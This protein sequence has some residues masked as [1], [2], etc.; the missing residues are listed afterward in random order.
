MDFSEN[1]VAIVGT[2][3]VPNY[4]DLLFPL[5]ASFK[6]GLTDK[7][8]L[9]ISPTQRK[10]YF[11]D[12]RP[13]MTV[14]DLLRYNMV[15]RALLIGGGNIVHSGSAN[16][17]GYYPAELDR[18]AYPSL[19]IGAAA[20]ASIHNIPL[21]WNAPGVP[22][23]LSQMAA[24]VM[25]HI[26]R[27][28]SYI[29]VRD[30]SS[31]DNLDEP[32]DVRTSIIPD[33]VFSL[34]ELWAR[35]YLLQRFRALLQAH[36]R[37]DQ[38]PYLAIHVKARS[39]DA[40]IETMAAQIDSLS[41]K[42]GMTPILIALGHCHDDHV[43]ADRISGLLASEHINFARLTTLVDVAATLVGS[44]GY[45]GAS[46][47][48]YI[49]AVSYGVPA[50]IIGKP[51]LPKTRAV[52]GLLKREQDLLNCWQDAVDLP[53]VWITGDAGATER[54]I[55]EDLIPMLDRHWATIRHLIR[56]DDASKAALRNRLARLL[57]RYQIANTGISRFL[58]ALDQDQA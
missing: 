35:D 26:L 44:R 24:H 41:Q 2:F 34:P 39:L 6:L 58:A 9:L 7:D 22:F 30:Q 12:A 50:R 51:A 36:G 4:G 33:T 29:S 55:R 18:S 3:D 43:T 27:A 16:L 13:T 53:P 14:N 15:P 23:P 1:P 21:I 38:Q 17:P 46:M 8:L 56:Q 25:K 37:S 20:L 10:V 49:T 40:D 5:I 42:L 45:L 32:D 28:S 11:A 48:G 57:L 54:L 31:L 52:T 19:W 47:H